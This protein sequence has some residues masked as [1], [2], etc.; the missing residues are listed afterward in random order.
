MSGDPRTHDERRD[1]AA[2]GTAERRAD[3]RVRDH[4]QVH[5]P[6][7]DELRELQDHGR[8]QRK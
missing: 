4:V 7:T 1:A 6:G 3:R 5:R 8:P 2:A